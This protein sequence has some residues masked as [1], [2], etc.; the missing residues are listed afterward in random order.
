MSSKR[1]AVIVSDFNRDITGKMLSHALTLLEKDEVAVTVIHVP[2][3]FEIPFAVHRSIKKENVDGIVTLGAVIKGQ[4]KH[5]ELIMQA[6]APKLLELSLAHDK[7]VSLGIIGP[8]ASRQEAEARVEEYAQRA[9]N[10]LLAIIG[11][12]HQ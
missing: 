11:G 7:P 4:T 10:S 2:G 3:A 6:I 1:I 12:G 5:D 9:V 8:G